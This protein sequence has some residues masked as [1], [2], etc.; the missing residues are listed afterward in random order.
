MSGGMSGYVIPRA[1]AGVSL[2]AINKLVQAFGY[3]PLTELLWG[4]TPTAPVKKEEPRPP[5]L[6]PVAAIAGERWAELEA[7]YENKETEYGIKDAI[8]KGM[9]KPEVMKRAA[10][11]NPGLVG[12]LLGQMDPSEL[13]KLNLAEL[14]GDSKDP[15][16]GRALLA[17]SK[18]NAYDGGEQM[19]HLSTQVSTDFLNNKTV[20][21]GPLAPRVF[22]KLFTVGNVDKI[23]ELIEA[24]ADTTIAAPAQ[25]SG[26]GI[27]SGFVQPLQHIA[28][29]YLREIELVAKGQ[30]PEVHMKG[31][32][33][34]AKQVLEKLKSS[35]TAE[36]LTSYEDVKKS[37]LITTFK[38]SPGTIWGFE[39]IRLPYVEAAHDSRDE[40]APV[41]MM[42]LWEAVA[43]AI[44]SKTNGYGNLLDADDLDKIIDE[45][46]KQGSDEIESKKSSSS[47]APKAKY[48]IVKDKKDYIEN[49]KRD[50]KAMLRE[51]S[52]Q[53]PK[54]TYTRLGE[55]TNGKPISDVA[56]YGADKLMNGMACKAGLWW[57][58]KENKPIYYCLDG[59][60]WKD[61]TDYKVV[62]NKAIEAC[63]SGEAPPHHEVITLVE[64]REILKNWDELKGIVKF[65]NKGKLMTPEEAEEEVKKRII[66]MKEANTRAGRAP[67]PP[68]ATFTKQL[69]T[70]DPNLITQLQGG[71]DEGDENARKER[72][73][74]ARDLVR[75]S[76]YFEKIGKT[77]PQ[78]LLKY[79]M[80]KCGVL[81]TYKLIAAE[82]VEAAQQLANAKG[83]EEFQ[84]VGEKMKVAIGNCNERFRA[85][86][87]ACLRTHP[88][89][90]PLIA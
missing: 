67:A 18:Y 85:P 75:K 73:K 59:V 38:D 43:P 61:V 54:G 27:Y 25:G 16:V 81:V 29:K 79:L 33:A 65:S 14:F 58:K 90:G 36:T 51:L 32:I 28:Q 46:V 10:A 24:G 74:D 86:L 45:Y 40:G 70:L 19:A 8:Q 11:T 63:L 30:N 62:K 35:G 50:A 82:L 57:A 77:R 64:L 89:I 53:M 42:E 44:N 78:I 88:E 13:K 71:L 7:A 69:T 3:P 26:G 80:S 6:D 47:P 84:R 72:D 60:D 55:D 52:A 37:D 68:L 22:Q 21:G 15:V 17:I 1:L 87:K 2:A 34:N 12:A 5:A 83:K 31:Q 49:F 56:G 20:V 48:H 9:S 76:G 23:A 4:S 66:E 41:R 39:D